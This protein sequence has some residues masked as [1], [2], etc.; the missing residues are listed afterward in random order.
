MCILQAA[1]STNQGWL[2]SLKGPLID[3]SLG[4]NME[5]QGL[6]ARIWV[7]HGP[8]MELQIIWVLQ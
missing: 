5:R 2:L 1:A 6:I 8:T 3:P 7:R 4:P